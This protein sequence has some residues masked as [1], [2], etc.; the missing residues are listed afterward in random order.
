MTPDVNGRNPGFTQLGGAPRKDPKGEGL[1]VRQG[2][3]MTRAPTQIRLITRDREW[4]PPS[5]RL[6]IKSRMDFCVARSGSLCSQKGSKRLGS[7]RSRMSWRR[8]SKTFSLLNPFAIANGYP[9]KAVLKAVE[10]DVLLHLFLPDCIHKMP[11]D[12][13]G[14]GEL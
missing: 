3:K 1:G 9:L 13:G 10:R 4:D 14:L 6:R 2:C 7:R 11:T 8:S 5:E 12:T